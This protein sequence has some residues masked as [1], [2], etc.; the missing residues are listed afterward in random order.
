MYPV[1]I[2][3]AAVAELV[4][5]YDWYEKQRPGLGEELLAEFET[6]QRHLEKHPLSYP[7]VDG[8]TRRALTRRFPYGVFYEILE[9]Q[10]VITA[11]FHSKRDPARWY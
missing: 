8:Q 10:V 11:F 2:A 1:E 6:V 7:V 3:E 9:N 4:D 5:A